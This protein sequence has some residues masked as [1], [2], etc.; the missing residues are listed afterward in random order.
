MLYVLLSTW[1]NERLLLSCFDVRDGRPATFPSTSGRSWG[2]LFGWL[3]A[4]LFWR[5]ND[6]LLASLHDGGSMRVE[7]NSELERSTR[8]SDRLQELL[9][10]CESPSAADGSLRVLLEEEGR[11]GGKQDWSSRCCL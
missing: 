6:N 4:C 2:F 8:T 3:A 7:R 11:G 10:P 9:R 1:I 5:G